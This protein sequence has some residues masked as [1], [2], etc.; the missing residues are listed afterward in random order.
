MAVHFGCD[1]VVEV[2]KFRELR[3]FN[4]LKPSCHYMYR[5]FNIHQFCILPTQRIYM[6]C[7]DLRTNGDYFPIQH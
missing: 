3:H 7:V 5:Q 2:N 4:P 6:F 1:V